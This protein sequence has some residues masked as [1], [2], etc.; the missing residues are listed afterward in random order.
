L[1]NKNRISYK[2]NS[3]FLLLSILGFII[4]A[5]F[6]IVFLKFANQVMIST[7]GIYFD[8]KVIS[9]IHKGIKPNIKNIMVIISFLGSVSFYF[10][11]APFLIWHLVKNKHH[12]ELLALLTSIL[13]SYGLNA[14]L[15][16][17]FERIRPEAYFLVEQGGFSFP[18][19][20]AM[21][22]M[23]FYGMATYLLVRNKKWDIKKI[24]LWILTIVFIGLMGF[25][26]IYLGVH[27][28]TDVIAGF[29]GGFIWLYFCIIGVEIAHRKL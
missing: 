6:L 25:S 18:S 19:G 3:R 26:R 5:G 20:H 14:T 21:I 16:N 4:S 27:W 10:L 9:S 24:S 23:S 2:A 12:I 7:G 8:E 15:K 13:G 17:Y 11:I 1:K 29:G 22:A 28:P